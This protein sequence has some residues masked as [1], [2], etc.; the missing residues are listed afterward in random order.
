M[1][2]QTPHRVAVL[3]DIHGNVG[4]LRAVL[5]DLDSLGVD[6]IVVAGDVVGFGPNPAEVVDLLA[7]RSALMVRGNH[8]K[9][10]VSVYGTAEMPDSWW[11]APRTKSLLWTMERLG[12]ERRAFLAALPDRLLLDDATLVVHGSPRHVR[13]KILASTPDE[14]LEAMLDGETASLR[15]SSATRT[16]R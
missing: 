1:S 13:D 5:A 12:P 10:Y 14:E 9:D 6:R 16:A 15:P 4:A 8:E 2:R 7:A 11:T 3:S